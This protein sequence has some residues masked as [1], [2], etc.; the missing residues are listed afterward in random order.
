MLQTSV[1][2]AMIVSLL[3]MVAFGI[4]KIR[5]DAEKRVHPPQTG[6]ELLA[7]VNAKGRAW[8]AKHPG[9]AEAPYVAP[10][11]VPVKPPRLMSEMTLREW[12]AGQALA[13]LSGYTVASRPDLAFQLAD[14]MM[15][16]TTR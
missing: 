13:G 1:I 6:T 4:S 9:L 16:R 7:S 8:Y 2:I 5:D 3:F 11:A 14:E 10:P 15:A 12:Y